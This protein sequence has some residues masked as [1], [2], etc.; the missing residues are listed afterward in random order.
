MNC[1]ADTLCYTLLQCWSLHPGGTLPRRVDRVKIDPLN[2]LSRGSDILGKGVEPSS[3]NPLPRQIQTC[4]ADPEIC[5]MERAGRHF[6]ISPV[7]IYRK[8]TQ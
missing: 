7:V 5:K 8:Y 3:P 6:C 4:S 1:V 2:L